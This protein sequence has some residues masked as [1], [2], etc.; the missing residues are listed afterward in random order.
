MEGGF[1]LFYC[2]DLNFTNLFLVC[3]RSDC[4]AWFKGGWPLLGARLDQSELA[5]TPRFPFLV[6]WGIVR[7]SAS[8]N[9]TLVVG[10][11]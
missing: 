7:G 9:N 10:Q 1:V 4:Q 6:L 3:L 5:F 8:A 11:K 2:L